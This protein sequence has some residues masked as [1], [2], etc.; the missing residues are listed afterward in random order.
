MFF[1]FKVIVNTIKQYGDLF[2]HEIKK[3][4]YFIY[5]NFFLF[6]LGLLILCSNTDETF[7]I[8]FNDQNN[9][10][11]FIFA[12]KKAMLNIYFI[13]SCAHKLI[14]NKLRPP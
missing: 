13:K 3:D 14:E 6:I 1:A 4:L 8:F 12:C 9:S 5:L 11:H 2:I 7:I 10:F